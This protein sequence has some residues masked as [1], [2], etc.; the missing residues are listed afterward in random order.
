MNRTYILALV[1]VLLVGVSGGFYWSDL[2]R[3]PA[4][5]S[6]IPTNTADASFAKDQATYAAGSAKVA[7]LSGNSGTFS[8]DG[9][10]LK[11]LATGSPIA[12]ASAEV[13]K[14]P[15]HQDL[16]NY[17]PD[18]S[19]KITAANVAAT[20]KALVGTQT[21][22]VN[23][24]VNVG[25]LF[26]VG[27]L[28]GYMTNLSVTASDA[29]IIDA[30][31]KLYNP[32]AIALGNQVYGDLS[33]GTGISNSTAYGIIDG[34][35]HRINDAYGGTSGSV[36]ILK[37]SSTDAT[38]SFNYGPSFKGYILSAKVGG[39][40]TANIGSVGLS[41]SA[42][43]RWRDD[44]LDALASG[45]SGFLG[46]TSPFVNVDVSMTDPKTGKV[47]R[48]WRLGFAISDPGNHQERFTA[49]FSKKF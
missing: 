9:T 18:V 15:E 21:T 26:N 24:K 40:I 1:A 37:S 14:N 29:Q 32:A 4:G 30:L 11:S 45:F 36:G 33:N 39:S 10:T 27:G 17:P 23:F 13:C 8:S 6:Y 41:L 22:T 46:T 49:A 7:A 19:D 20:A 44:C 34:A 48:D 43:Y 47:V 42:G 12:T 38:Y 31:Y 25:T 28:K 35:F 5:A 3:Q 16:T 2:Q